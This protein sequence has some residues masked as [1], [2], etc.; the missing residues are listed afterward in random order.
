[1][2]TYT[3]WIMNPNY[4]EYNLLAKRKLSAFHSA[5]TSDFPEYFFEQ[6]GT[7]FERQR[8]GSCRPAWTAWNL[9]YVSWKGVG[10]LSTQR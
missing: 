4:C 3:Q 2:D 1:M 9:Q 6:L 7:P 8:L 10:V 5:G